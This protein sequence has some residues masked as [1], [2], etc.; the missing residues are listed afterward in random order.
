[1][2]HGQKNTLQAIFFVVFCLQLKSYIA[3]SAPVVY[4]MAVFFVR[5]RGYVQQFEKK[6]I[7]YIIVTK[8]TLSSLMKYCGLQQSLKLVCCSWRKYHK[9]LESFSV[10][11]SE[12]RELMHFES[13]ASKKNW[14]MSVLIVSSRIRYIIYKTPSKEEK[15]NTDL[16]LPVIWLPEGNLILNAEFPNFTSSP[17]TVLKADGDYGCLW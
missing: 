7:D 10:I 9:L 8:G 3:L 14:L 15:S 5:H 2:P 4:F 17:N 11:M 16:N 12:E 1:M 13:V 6:Y